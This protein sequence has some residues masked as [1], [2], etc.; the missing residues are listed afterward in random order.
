MPG[1]R[2]HVKA[3]VTGNE[4]GNM[5]LFCPYAF[6]SDVDHVCGAFCEVHKKSK[7]KTKAQKK[8]QGAD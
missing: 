4:T 7:G 3:C 5:G 8:Y 6:N 2:Q 1:G